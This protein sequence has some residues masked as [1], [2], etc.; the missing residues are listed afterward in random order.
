MRVVIH[1]H[2][3]VS[4]SHAFMCGFVYRM[5]GNIFY[6]NM[7]IANMGRKKIVKMHTDICTGERFSSIEW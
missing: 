3:H 5:F 2:M 1:V 4:S 7:E 6:A